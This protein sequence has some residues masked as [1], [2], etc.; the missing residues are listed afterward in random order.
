MTRKKAHGTGEALQ[1]TKELLDY[2]FKELGL[3]KVY[4]NV[5]E[6]NIR[7]RK[8]YEKCGFMQEGIAKD[9][10]RIAEKYISLVW[11]GILE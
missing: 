9:A 3:H 2:A 4:L 7:A 10:I 5:M 11:Y 1:A 6:D 8:F